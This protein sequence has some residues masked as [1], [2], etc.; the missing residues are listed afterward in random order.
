MEEE[1]VDPQV[2]YRLAAFAFKEGRIDIARALVIH[3]LKPKINRRLEL[4]NSRPTKLKKLPRIRTIY[5]GRNKEVQKWKML[6]NRIL[7]CARPDVSLSRQTL[8]W[9]YQAQIAKVLAERAVSCHIQKYL[10]S[11]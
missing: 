10:G 9:Q 2:K 5:L 3:Q 8:G 4:P 11:A 6:R 7:Q 1:I